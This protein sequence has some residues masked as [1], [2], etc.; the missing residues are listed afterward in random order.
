[1]IFF[2]FQD[3]DDNPLGRGGLFSLISTAGTDNDELDADFS[4]GFSLFEFFVSSSSLNSHMITGGVPELSLN[5][6]FLSSLDKSFLL[7]LLFLLLFEAEQD[8]SLAQ[9]MAPVVITI[10]QNNSDQSD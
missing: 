5:F 3:M 8:C 4:G 7:L 9:D 6:K 10:Y 2:L 1:M